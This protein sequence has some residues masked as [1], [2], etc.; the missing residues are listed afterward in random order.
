LLTPCDK[1]ALP[2]DIIAA[3]ENPVIDEVGV[4]NQWLQHEPS[5][6]IKNTDTWGAWQ[7]NSLAWLS[8]HSAKQ[9][10]RTLSNPIDN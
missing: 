6:I 9:T 5:E 4:M 2:A 10:N 3:K 1:A 7:V 8:E